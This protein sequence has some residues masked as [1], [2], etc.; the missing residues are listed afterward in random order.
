MFPNLQ[1]SGFSCSEVPYEGVCWWSLLWK[2]PT[3]ESLQ[4]A[5]VSRYISP[6]LYITLIILTWV[7]LPSHK[8]ATVSNAIFHINSHNVHTADCKSSMV[9]Y[10]SKHSLNV[11]QDF[12]HLFA[13]LR[14][15][16]WCSFVCNFVC[17][18]VACVRGLNVCTGTA[19]GWCGV[20]GAPALAPAASVN[21]SASG[22]SSPPASTG[23]GVRTSWAA[24]WKTVSVVFGPAAVS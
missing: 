20:S 4:S 16:W 1:Q 3:G 21:S 2:E 19:P 14:L 22:P 10:H 17:Q 23:P 5:S 13:H 8:E 9:V 12:F 15:F 6:H 11:Q 24:T 18:M 7:L